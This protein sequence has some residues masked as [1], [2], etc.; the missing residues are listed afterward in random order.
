MMRP[1]AA[2]SAA[3]SATE[4]TAAIP[5]RA[6]IA[7]SFAAFGSGMSMR[8]ADSMLVRLA[9]DFGIALGAAAMVINVFGFAYG[10]S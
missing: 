5:S 1:S 9:A 10:L 4:S 3:E 8:I 7:L 6:I 2:E